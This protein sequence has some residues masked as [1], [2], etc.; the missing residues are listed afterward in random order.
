MAVSEGETQ[1][2][3]Y[4]VKIRIAKSPQSIEHRWLL[5]RRETAI[6]AA[7]AAID[8]ARIGLD[9]SVITTMLELWSAHHD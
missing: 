9:E 3:A 6:A 7:Y 5:V 4:Y 2:P 8:E 1:M